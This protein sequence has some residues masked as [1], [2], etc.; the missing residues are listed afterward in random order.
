MSS[1]EKTSPIILVGDFETTSYKGQTTTEVWASAVVEIG[2]DD[3]IVT[4]NIDDTFNY[5]LSFKQDV[6][7]YYHN[8]KFDGSFWIN[9]LFKNGYKLA[10]HE[11]K[12]N[13]Y[14]MAVFE[15]HS[16]RFF[17]DKWLRPMTF[18]VM[19]S[20]QGMWYR[21]IIKT[22]TARIEIRDSL[23]LLPF[24]VEEIG[25][26][27]GTKHK[28]AVDEH[29]SSIEYSKERHEYGE[30]SPIEREYIKNDVLVVKEALE[31]MFDEG[32]DKL[33]IGSCCL[34]EYI[35]EFERKVGIS[36]ADNVNDIQN[37][38][39]RVSMIDKTDKFDRLWSNEEEHRN[40][41]FNVVHN[42]IFDYVRK[43]YRGGWTYLAKGKENKVYRNGITIDVNSLYPSVMHSIL[44]YK[45]P[46]RYIDCWNG[47]YI[48]EWAEG[49][50]RY[51]FIRFRCSFKLKEG[52]LPTLQIK[53]SFNYNP[54]EML[55]TSDILDRAYLKKTGKERRYSEV[56]KDGVLTPVTV[57]LTMTETDYRMFLVHYEVSNFEILDGVY[58]EAM[59]GIF[60][61]YIDKYKQIKMNSKGALR[62]LAKLF[63]NNL[64]GKMATS[65]DSSFKVPYINE[66]GG[67]SFHMCL[68]YGKRPGYI[69][70]G[71]AITSY[72]RC[73]TITVAQLNYHGPAKPGFI[74]ADTDS[75]HMDIP[76]SEVK[77][78]MIHDTEFGCW[79]HES[80]WDTAIFVRPK[81][82]IEHIIGKHS[83]Y[84]IK[85]AG[86][87]KRG[88]AL[89]NMSLTGIIDDEFKFEED[90][91]EFASTKR[92]LTDFKMGIEIPGKLMPK[93]IPGGVVLVRTTF[94]MQ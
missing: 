42:T 94:K 55:E 68:E 84:D 60:D 63:L 29:G 74:Y 66:K 75:C 11:A 53:N 32:H 78:V 21:I 57:E 69:P 54:R 81:T 77:G 16:Y 62:T 45:Y 51:F 35:D 41:F 49:E 26:S 58:F 91:L 14:D 31:I 23:K 3:V 48:P 39:I 90:E 82:Y 6:I 40:L 89:L 7:I 80:S 87:P 17:W 4:N 28:K 71:S 88:K 38:Y 61:D 64:Y 13:V 59:T 22:K 9:Y 20:N 83:Y 76:I 5:L 46:V 70:I 72:A 18:S 50:N 86:L 47:N 8:L 30:I 10:G 65:T 43:S 92:E 79:A 44:N 1:W 56:M 15:N 73:F 19:I 36:L 67:L 34:D 27:F 85:C 52:M 25:K 93:Q 2:S 24:S 37:K 12:R 33:T